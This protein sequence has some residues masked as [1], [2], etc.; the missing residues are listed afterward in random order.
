MKK[1]RY[2]NRKKINLVLDNQLSCLSES[3]RPD[4]KLLQEQFD[5]LQKTIDDGNTIIENRHFEISAG[6]LVLS[7]T[8]LSLLSSLNKLPSNYEWVSI[9][10]WS[11]FTISIL[12]HY[13]SQF[14]SV[15]SA[16]KLQNN[17]AEM[18]RKNQKYDDIELGLKYNEA[19]KGLRVVNVL[20][21]VF[22]LLG[23]LGLTV[24]T[25]VCIMK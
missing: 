4:L 21:F 20:T 18:I 19:Q 24:Y 3:D 8:I 10:I 22:M 16:R 9:L 11:F 5:S 7:L 12:L 17:V 14:I 25:G 1:L 15:C 2:V 23:I 13:F 6:G